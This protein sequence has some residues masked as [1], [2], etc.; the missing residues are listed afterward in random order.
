[1]LGK[2]ILSVL[3]FLRLTSY[4]DRHVMYSP[5]TTISLVKIANLIIVAL[6]QERG[7][8]QTRIVDITPQR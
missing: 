8:N 1:M 3:L 2:L 4:G 7:L 5:W 6:R